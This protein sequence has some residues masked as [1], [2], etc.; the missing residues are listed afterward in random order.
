MKQNLI[1]LINFSEYAYVFYR[2]SKHTKC[3]VINAEFK[4]EL[5][6][7]KGLIIATNQSC[8]L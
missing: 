1:F 4:D 6:H 2:I 5:K 7:K 3:N 8:T